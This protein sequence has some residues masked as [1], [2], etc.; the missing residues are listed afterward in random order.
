MFD[1]PIK[2][3]LDFAIEKNI[4]DFD[5]AYTAYRAHGHKLSQMNFEEIRRDWG[6]D[7]HYDYDVHCALVTQFG[8]FED[9]I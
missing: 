1:G 9:Q 6:K 7:K 8:R 4:H 5:K 3:F 2:R